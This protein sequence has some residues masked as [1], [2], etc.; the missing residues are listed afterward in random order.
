VPASEERRELSLRAAIIGSLLGV[1]FGASSVY[2][3]LK[4]GITV[5]ASI[6][7]AVLSIPIFRALGKGSILENNITQTVG[8]AGES[9]AAGVV[10]TVPALLVLG[11]DLDLAR[12]TLIALTGGWLGVMLMIPLRRSLI[13]KEHG[14]LLYPEGTACAEVLEAGEKKGV[15]A[16]KVFL[17]LGVGLVYKFLYK[18]LF[19]WREIPTWFVASYKGADFEIEASPELMG[20]GYIIGPRVGGIMMAGGVLSYLVLMPLIRF[21]GEHLTTPLFPADKLIAGMSNGEIRSNYIYYIGAG[22]VAAGGIISLARAMPTIIGTFAA[23]IKGLGAHGVGAGEQGAVVPRTE[24]DMPFSVTL[25]GVAIIAI[26]IAAIPR[27]EVNPIA[28]VLIVVFGFFF[29]TVSSRITGQIGSSSNPVSGMTIAT[30]LLTSL[31]FV[32]VGWEGGGYRAIALTVGAIVCIA[33]SNGGATSQ[34]LKTGF[35][36][37]STPRRQQI[38]LLVG[39]T[40]SALVV[41]WTL[42]FVNSVYTQRIDERVAHPKRYGAITFEVPP[43]AKSVTGPDGKSYKDVRIGAMPERG[44]PAG[45]VLVD[46]TGHVAYSINPG[47]VTKGRE[48]LKVDSLGRPIQAKDD[49]GDPA[50]QMKDGAPVLDADGDKIPVWQETKDKFEAPKAQLM[51]LIIDGILNRKLPWSLVLFGV[52]ISIV[53]ELAGIDAL[54]FAV[55]LYLPLSSSS[56]IFAGGVVRWLVSRRTKTEE[57]DAGSGVLLSSGLIAGGS[58]CG[59]LVALVVAFTKSEDAWSVPN[60]LGGH[61]ALAALMNGNWLSMICFFALGTYLYRQSTR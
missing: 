16:K 20:V 55:G 46:D 44:I 26:L 28:A 19:L 53:L 35:L 40:T 47:I 34:D 25:G 43:G 12:T 5:S 42:L 22:A 18:A 56:P 33:V 59:L 36:V 37:G 8:S 10:F 2:L 29:T 17:G 13:V 51:A 32:S 38:G 52:F 49:N 39:V 41:G 11:Y 4:V 58:L 7:I 23:A 1:V 50:W 15:Q 3:A 61:S 27:L 30:L 31:V 9:I 60:M 21:F 45:H 57:S 14:K 48:S 6:P 24:R 54:P